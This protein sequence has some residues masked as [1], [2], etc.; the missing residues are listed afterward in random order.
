MK[1]LWIFLMLVCVT[2]GCLK[3]AADW[4]ADLHSE[5]KLKNLIR[6]VAG[7]QV[8]QDALVLE[9]YSHGV[10]DT[11]FWCVLSAE[12]EEAKALLQSAEQVLGSPIED[13]SFWV[14]L[15]PTAEQT[16]PCAPFIEIARKQSPQVHLFPLPPGDKNF[17]AGT[18]VIVIPERAWVIIHHR[19]S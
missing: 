18:M 7:I 16:G 11:S 6:K 2:P 17:T 14:G 13:K 9:A 8:P 1:H 19:N 15:T 4:K 12:K 3:M 5:E 10:R